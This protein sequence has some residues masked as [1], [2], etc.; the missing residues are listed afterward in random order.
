MTSFFTKLFRK[1]TTR[2]TPS[3]PHDVEIDRDQPVAE[4]AHIGAVSPTMPLPQIKQHLEAPQL[5][6]GVGQSV[7]IQRDHN[8]D[9]LFT[10]T[11]NLLSGQENLYFGLY[12]VAD[13][14][15]GHEHGEIASSLA[16]TQLTTHVINSLFLP[17]MEEGGDKMDL[18][19]QEVMYTGMIQAHQKVKQ[20]AIG[21]GTTLTAALILGDQLTIAHVGDSRA[22]SLD[23]HGH[24]QLLTHDHSLV[25]R[26]EEIGQITP[27]Q[28]SSHPQRNVLYRALGQGE[29]FTPDINTYHLQL[30]S[31][32]LI[33]TDGLWGV[34]S[35]NELAEVLHS[36][37][38]PQHA[39]QS[40]IRSAN[41]AG[42]PDNISVII[43]RIPE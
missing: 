2:Q 31:Q 23:P 33:C 24:L 42:G 13:G 15:G 16:V 30:G 35:D 12:L 37:P 40:L 7:G 17:I 28:V 21:G 8:E 43:V 6:V 38:D 9:S 19:L 1:K 27:E 41:S 18:S 4:S 14:M 5:T 34:I 39:C 36:S 10:L 3:P 26:L 11:T 25:K 22:Y 32:L 20:V 29:P